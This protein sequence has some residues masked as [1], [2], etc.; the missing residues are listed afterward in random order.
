MSGARDL[1]GWLGAAAVTAGLFAG[2]AAAALRGPLAPAGDGAVEAVALDLSVGVVAMAAVLPSTPPTV[3]AEAPRMAEAEVAPEVPLADPV[4]QV[5]PVAMPR[6]DL[7][8]PEMTLPEMT[9]PEAEAPPILP[10]APPPPPEVA[11]PTRELA[12]S[13]RPQPR[14]ER[15]RRSPETPAETAEAP[16]R[17]PAPE[18]Q[19][20]EAEAAP[21]AAQAAG[22]TQAVRPAEVRRAAGGQSAAHYGDVVMRQIAKLRRQKAPERG[23]VTVGFEIGADGGLRRVAVV[24]SSGS[25]ALDQVAV[26]HIRRAAPF[27]PPPEGAATR[28]AFEFVG[29]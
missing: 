25:V 10:A 12:V 22:A 29:R 21:A 1:A 8:P 3:V 15:A 23:K 27:P 14:P 19:T 6:P 5:A 13:P 26:D 7:A 20:A 18:K 16:R 11:E 9:L 28:F 4:P 17:E 24:A 2:A